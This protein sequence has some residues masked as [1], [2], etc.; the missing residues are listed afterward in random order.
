VM[1]QSEHIALHRAEIEEGL[2]L[3]RQRSNG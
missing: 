2:R 1:T 3:A